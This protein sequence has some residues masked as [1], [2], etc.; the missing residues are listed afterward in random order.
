MAVKN[1][2]G[3]IAAL[4]IS[5]YALADELQIKP[6]H[7]KQYTVVRGDT[8]WDI[9]GKFLQ[10]PWLWPKLWHGN[11][12]V[13]NPHLIY[14]GDVLHLDWVDGKPYLRLSSGREVKLYPSIRTS[15]LDGAIKMIP[16]DAIAQFLTSPKVLDDEKEIDKAAYIIDF[17]DEHIVVG[18]GDRVYARKILKPTTLNYTFFRKG[19]PYVSPETKEILGYEAFY[20]GE[21]TLN[22]A[23]DPATLT[24]T[25]SNSEIRIGDRLMEN[26]EDETALNFFP[27]A[28][29]KKLKEIF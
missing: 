7:P 4:L 12:Q 3:L 16:T 28:P 1:T 29:S 15:V 25:K 26:T 10:Q 19:E 13:K 11:P 6:D 24:V 18:K 9:S 27:K 14:P 5:F 23:G 17:P 22:R 8:L 20:L 21:A 2:L